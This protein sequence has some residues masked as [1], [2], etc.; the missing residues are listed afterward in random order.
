MSFYKDLF[1][2]NFGNDDLIIMGLNSVQKKTEQSLFFNS[3]AIFD[4][5]LDLIQSY[6]KVNLV[7]FGE[8]T[9]LEDLLNIMGIKTITNG[10]QSFSSGSDRMPLIIKNDKI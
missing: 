1:L 6:N 4:N 7:P 8:F 2:D 9:P 5:K 3:M 10:Y